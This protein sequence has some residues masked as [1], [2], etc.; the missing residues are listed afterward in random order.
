MSEEEIEQA[1][2]A[3]RFSEHRLMLLV[4]GAIIV[5]LFLVA[6]SM[7]LYVQSGAA[8][9]D[10]SRPGYKSVQD[11]A[12]PFDNFQGFSSDGPIN[13]STLKD[14]K[15]LYNKQAMQ[16]SGPDAFGS[17]ALSNQ[18]LRIDESTDP[19]TDVPSL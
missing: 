11:K 19:S 15:Q 6:V 13:S 2:I 4:V 16:A 7:A 12:Q 9:L 14:F 17:D 10:L 3:S 5:S 18:S 8:Q 1:S